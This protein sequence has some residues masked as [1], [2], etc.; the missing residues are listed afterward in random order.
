MKKEFPGVVSYNRFVEL[1]QK[2]LLPLAV[3]F[4]NLLSW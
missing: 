4:K 1:M 2:V 3:Y